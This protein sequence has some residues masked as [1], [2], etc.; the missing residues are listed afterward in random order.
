MT[1]NSHKYFSIRRCNERFEKLWRLL[2][3]SATCRNAY[4]TDV[5]DRLNFRDEEISVRKRNIRENS[6]SDIDVKI[7]NNRSVSRETI[8]SNECAIAYIEVS[9]N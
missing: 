5:D 4:A 7:S 1:Q 2:V 8:K 6:M 3:E 9:V